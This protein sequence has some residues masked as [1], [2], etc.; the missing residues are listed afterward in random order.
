MTATMDAGG[1]REF[2][3]DEDGYARWLAAHPR[4]FVVNTGRAKPAGY[5]VLHRASCWTIRPGR[6]GAA[7]GAFTER[8]Y[9]KVCAPELDA[10]RRA[11]GPFS[12]RCSVCDVPAG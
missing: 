11:V 4:G 1:V 9:I 8:D 12:G 10:L 7:P 3:L 5:R 2:M 6:K